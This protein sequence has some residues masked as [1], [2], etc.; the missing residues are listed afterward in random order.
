MMNLA[1]CAPHAGYVSSFRF[2]ISIMNLKQ[3]FDDLC[4]LYSTVR[5]PHSTQRDIKGLKLP[6]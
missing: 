1:K 4:I 6:G 2:K 3:V 5:S